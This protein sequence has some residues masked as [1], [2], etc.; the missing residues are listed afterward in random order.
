[1]KSI[2]LAIG[3]LLASCA[4]AVTPAP[5][6]QVA[7]ANATQA[8]VTLGTVAAQSNTTA[9]KIV[10]GGQLLCNYK[11]IIE[12]VAGV[13]VKGTLATEM[14]AVCNGLGA[15]G[16]ALPFSVPAASVPLVKAAGT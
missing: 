7:E 4:T 14:E 11:G 8:V 13:N 9:A 16:T 10:A 2:I 5:P 1:M 12:A 3:L 6:V 15:T